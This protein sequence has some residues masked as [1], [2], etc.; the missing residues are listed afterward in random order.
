VNERR[1]LAD[2]SEEVLRHIH[3]LWGFDVHL[4]SVSDLKVV[5]QYRC[6]SATPSM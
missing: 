3:R 5:T 6:P 4:Q 1:P 2:D